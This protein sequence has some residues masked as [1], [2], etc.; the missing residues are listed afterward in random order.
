MQSDESVLK[1]KLTERLK[2]ERKCCLHCE[3]PVTKETTHL[4][5]C[6]HIDP[7]QK[8]ESVAAMIQK[9]EYTMKDVEN[10][11]AK[12]QLLCCNCH[13]SKTAKDGNWRKLSDFSPEVIK[14]AEVFLDQHFKKDALGNYIHIR[15]VKV[16]VGPVGQPQNSSQVLPQ[17]QN[18]IQFQSTINWLALMPSFEM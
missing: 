14:K 8:I 10:E 2:L 5:D 3:I 6:D 18:P 13:R 12:C 17:P 7:E 4:F 1:R 11:I 16:Q 9:K 15:P